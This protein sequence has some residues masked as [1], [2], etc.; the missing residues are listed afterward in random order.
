MGFVPLVDAYKKKDAKLTAMG[1]QC[2]PLHQ[3]VLL[4]TTWHSWMQ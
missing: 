1:I 3:K 4:A 2:H